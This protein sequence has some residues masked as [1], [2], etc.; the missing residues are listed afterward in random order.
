MWFKLWIQVS[1]K[2]SL[3]TTGET[4]YFGTTESETFNM[5]QSHS[6]DYTQ[7]ID[8]ASTYE[9]SVKLV[10]PLMEYYDSTVMES[11]EAT[12][13][14]YTNPAKLTGKGKTFSKKHI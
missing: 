10:A 13:T 14:C 12:I 1:N 2:I 8:S 6:S 9:F 5:S 11:N 3:G 7:D 4:L